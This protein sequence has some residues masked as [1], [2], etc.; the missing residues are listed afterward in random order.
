MDREFLRLD[1][2]MELA[3]AL[4]M[5]SASGPCALVMDGENLVGLLTPDNLSEFVLFHRLGVGPAA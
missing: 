3:Q 1:P 5:I 2:G 4:P